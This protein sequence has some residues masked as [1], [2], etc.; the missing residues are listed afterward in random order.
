M[1]GQPLDR[2]LT[3]LD[4]SGYGSY[5]KLTG[6]RFPV[7][8]PRD[9]LELT[10]EH[11]QADPYAP[12]SALRVDL[13]LRYTGIPEDLLADPVPVRDHLLR[14][15]VEAIDRRN[16]RGGKSAGHLRIDVPGQEVLDRSA[17]TVQ[18]G[19]ILRIRL[20]AALP[21]HG[22]RI[23]GR[24][25]VDLLCG[26]LPDVL[27]DALLDL[28]E[29]LIEP[30]RSNVDIWREQQFLRSVLPDRNL[31]GFLADGAVLPRISGD[32][33]HPLK[34]AVPFTSPASLRTT[35]DLPSGRSI[36]GLGIPT[37]VTLIVGGGYHGKSTVLKALERG[38]YD[39]VPGD[40][41]EHCVTVDDAVTLRAED[42]RAVRDV[43]ISAFL[44]DLPGQ[45]EA[46]DTTRFSTTNASGSTSQAAGL[47]EACE[48]GAS[49]LLIDEDTS[50]TNFLVRDARMRVLVPADKEP[51]TPLVDRVRA[52][53]H[54]HG[55]ST[56][57][58]TGGSGA[59]LDVADT[60]IMLDAYHPVD[61]TTQARDLAEPVAESASFPMPGDRTPR[62]GKTRKPPQAKERDTIRHGDGEI[63]L[64]ACV[65][66]IDT[67]Q[68]RTIA[69]LLPLLDKTP[70]TLA[71]KAR[72]LRDR[73]RDE[74]WE[75]LPR[76][77]GSLALPRVQ[78][79]TAAVNRLR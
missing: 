45:T 18:N 58:V 29:E 2:V 11:V 43:D 1:T 65:Q 53:H 28:T 15:L 32:S 37:G 67:S 76:A 55:V 73:I 24:A 22:R 33:Q 41:R 47:V 52:L 50:A 49:C 8:D 79:I 69:A 40:G 5:R 39:H 62:V 64:S 7:G 35:I 74:G 68:T 17:V 66:L 57:L 60:V 20:Q 30:L 25:A 61:V 6:R 77:T 13:P 46:T 51:I 27:G 19:D 78:E 36:T 54:D 44:H 34:D 72:T 4:G 21:A 70:G 59:F 38:V 23:N 56:V 10:L 63:D 12:P 26:I 42:G 71:D 75:I 48:A 9:D 16:P 14:R 3:G 31:I